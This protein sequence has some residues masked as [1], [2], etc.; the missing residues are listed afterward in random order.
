MIPAA[1]SSGLLVLG[2]HRSGTSALARVLDLC[3][4][5][6]GARL[7]GESA[8]NDS[9]HWEDAVAV[10]L[11]ERL[12]ASLGARWDEAFGL[13]ADWSSGE[14]AAAARE[15]IRAYLE[16]SRSLHALWAVKDPR[17]SLFA[18]LWIDAARDAGQTL[19]AVVMLR[20]PLEVANSLSAR[21]GIAPGR[22]LLLW[23]DY[24]LAAV[25]AVEGLP[26][27]L[28]T[29]DQLLKDWRS[30]ATRIRDLP[31]GRNLEIDEAT[32]LAVDGFLDGSRRHHRETHAARMPKIISDVW[33]E[34][35]GLALEGSLPAGLGDRL[36]GEVASVREL[37]HP[38]LGE[39][40]LLQR[41]LWQRIYSSEI[42][43]PAALSRH[44]GQI[45]LGKKG[46]EDQNA[47][48]LG[49]HQ[50]VARQHNDVINAF[51]HDIRHMQEL[52]AAS[53]ERAANSEG[54][55][56]IAEQLA[57]QLAGRI[58]QLGARQAALQAE[59]LSALDSVGG[60]VERLA[61]ATQ[62]ATAAEARTNEARALLELELSRVA[63]KPGMQERLDSAIAECTQLQLDLVESQD[64]RQI[65]QSELETSRRGMESAERQLDEQRHELAV[66][67][68]ET[69]RLLDIASQHEQ[70]LHS[71]SWR[72]TKPL[73]L[74]RRLFSGQWSHSDAD[75]LRNL[76]CKVLLRL[77]V[78]AR[79]RSRLIG[80]TLAGGSS[81]IAAL[82]DNHVAMALDLAAAVEGLP[83]VFVWAVIDFNFR[84]QR[85]QHLARALAAKGHRVFYISV[86]FWDVDEPGFHFDPLDGCGRLYQIH[87]YLAGEPLIYT[88]MPSEEQVAALH[89]S[90]ASL[91][92][93]TRTT[94]SISLVQH[95]Y[96]NALVRSVPNARVVYDCM[97]HHAGFENNSPTVL[98]AER[99]LLKES[100]LV[101]VTSAWLE[102]EVEG[103]A[104]S[105]A[106][107]RNA[108]EFDF[109][110][111]PP[112]E[113][114]RD[115]HGRRV[116]GYYG[117]IAG[118]FDFD[119]VRR[120]AEAHPEVLVVLI[121]H[122][123]TRAAAPLAGLGNVLLVGEVAYIHLP[124]WL[125]A[126]DVCLL[127]FKVVP[128]TLATNPVKIYEYLAAGKSIVA[129]DLP[130]MA[131]F[132]GLIRTAAD[133][134]AFLAA[135][136]DALATPDDPEM[137][138][139]RQAFASRQ[140]WKH[141]AVE[142]DA[143]LLGL[144]EPRIS[145]VV[146]T[147]NNLAFTQ[148]CLHSVEAHSDYRNL[149]VIVV[150]NASSD[151]SVEY[152]RNWAAEPSAAGHARRLIL[153]DD[154]LGFA[155]GNNVGL[156]A[157]TGD[158]LVMLNNDTFVTPG[159]VRTMHAHL[160]RDKDLGL[161][162]PVTNNIGN[163]A[164]V[165]LCY[166]DMDQMVEQAGNYTRS[167]P[168]QAMPIDTVAFF[169]VMLP[170]A[171]YDSLGGLDEAFGLGFFEDDDYCRRVQQ[172]GLKVAC[173]EDVFVHHHLSAS[174]NQVGAERKKELFER[175]KAI[176]EAKWGTWEPHAYRLVS[177]AGKDS[178]TDRANAK[179]GRHAR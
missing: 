59:A 9:G 174:F 100:D 89:G 72:S 2:M 41:Q 165:E 66:F 141:R 25:K 30:C 142:L 70:V 134:D 45:E 87:L 33:T 85:P 81:T 150:D 125:H 147:Y 71:L 109:F 24:T 167:H 50:T 3:G 104:R 86:N 119:L 63:G 140:T 80:R 43:L 42:D 114:F 128:L 84:V 148:A 145:V 23:L 53:L 144:E 48:L 177:D 136:T 46:I 146:L 127:P 7:L 88:Q 77:P 120:V 160:L 135:V 55:V 111:E 39:Q 5:D 173:A 36:G 171:V 157:A 126:F 124:Y 122:D 121:G 16:G 105:T 175:N 179:R 161:V 51:S 79:L 74:A 90:L 115:E 153:N 54:K 18:D 62:A 75:R 14:A 34:L 95:P 10:E 65:L 163:E 158:V 35:S 149:E 129:V 31:G 162:G 178:G 13:P 118:W 38:L 112:A 57:G 132:D 154:N 82:P 106:L 6:I 67:R 164:R 47:A 169:C 98:E 110:R 176:Y 49:L 22:G 103:A 26:C 68:Q 99:S 69:E 133:P 152:L 8:G 37:V 170:R 11:H 97:D 168:G 172:A 52:V 139:I 12:L 73:R 143:A 107:I 40:R 64:A 27:V 21:D 151:G 117:A 4:A 108:G 60:M 166:A 76:W 78:G 17:L 131:Q 138:G 101:I 44:E 20:H 28:V 93:W 32:T 123:F 1:P 58:D 159:W 94:S 29:Y 96:W 130:E 155:A 102:S 116:I 91:L 61:Q 137:I 156:A 15:T 19:G 92:A 83:D 113:V 56:A